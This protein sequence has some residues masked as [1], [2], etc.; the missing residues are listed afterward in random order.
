MI[1]LN[2]FWLQRFCSNAHLAVRGIDPI[3]EQWLKVVRNIKM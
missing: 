3:L 1:R 2:K